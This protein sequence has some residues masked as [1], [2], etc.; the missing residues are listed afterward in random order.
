MKTLAIIIGAA[1]V[2]Y[3]MVCAKDWFDDM[4]NEE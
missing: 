2:A 4:N 3:L 1:I